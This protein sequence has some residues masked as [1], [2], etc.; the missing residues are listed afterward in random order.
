MSQPQLPINIP[1]RQD[2]ENDLKVDVAII[3]AGVSGLYTG[4]RLLTPGSQPPQT[5]HIFELSDRIG[6]RL[7]SV[8]LPGMGNVAGEL[9]GMRYMTSQKIVT[10]LIEE[11][12]Q[13]ELTSTGFPMGKPEHLLMY[14]RKQRFYANDWE[15]TQNQGEKLTTRYFLNDEDIGYSA[16]QLFNKI[17]YDVLVNDPCVIEKYRDKVCNHH[18]Y[19]YEFKLTSEDW[20][21]IKPRL[22]YCFEGSPYNGMLVNDIGFWNLIKDRVSQEGYQFLSDA[23]GYYSNTIN[24]NAAEAFPYMV[25]DFS[26]QQVTYKT[27]E[28][29]FDRIARALAK[30]Y[31]DRYGSTIWLKNALVS[32]DRVTSGDARYSLTMYNIDSGT[33]WKVFANTIV[34]AIPRRSL[35]LLDQYNFFFD[36]EKNQKLQ[37]NIHSVLVQPSYKLLMAFEDPWWQKDF[38]IDSGHSITDLPMRQ[39][40]YFGVNPENNHSLFLASYNDMETVPFWEVLEEEEIQF[41]PLNS[42][43]SKQGKPLIFRL[44]KE[45]EIVEKHPQL[46]RKMN[47]R[48][49]P[50][51]TKSVSR[52]KLNNFLD[53]QASQVMVNEVMNQIKELHSRDDIPNPY[54][55]YYKDWSED[56]FGGGYHAWKTKIDV[57]GVMEYM[58]QPMEEDAIHICGEAYS[59]QQG[60]V[61]GALC[62]AEKMLQDHFSMKRP[63]WL[64]SDYYLGW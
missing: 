41:E 62:V 54:I 48:F 6:G 64:P 30:A 7:E 58:R 46:K 17:V 12:F 20:D 42:F 61:E 29:G 49:Q 14:L 4:Y 37:K 50:K 13:K 31:T 18:E 33:E 10:T 1:S 9:G 8:N 5:V 47:D 26:D 2:F 23:G 19:K 57:Q 15:D 43:V 32:F 63:E 60:W 52:E 25:G 11:V 21:D 44:L 56:P 53:V 16:D 55:S 38:S 59:D 39:C 22:K 51:E 27:I 34:L 45:D 36:P 28:G 3:G 35:E 40:Y 24:W